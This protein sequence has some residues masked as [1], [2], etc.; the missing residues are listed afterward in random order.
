MAYENEITQS[1]IYTGELVLRI[2]NANK[3]TFYSGF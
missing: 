3:K 1:S 2:K